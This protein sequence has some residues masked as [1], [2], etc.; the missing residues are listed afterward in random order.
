V[1]HSIRLG[2]IHG[3]AIKVHPSFA[4][5]LLWVCYQWGIAAHAGLAGIVFGTLVLVAV[6][7]CVLLHE[8]AHAIV[9]LRYGV[10]VQD[11]TLLPV[12]GVARVDQ[13]AL[14]PKAEAAI[15]LAG[16][17]LNL[18]IAAALTPFVILVAAMRHADHPL[19][20]LLYAGEL[21]VAGFVLYLWIANILLAVFN[22]LPAFPMDGGRVLRAVLSSFR[23][24]LSATR[25]AV[26]IGQV[27]ALVLAVGG[28][29][30][31]DY[32]TPLISAFILVSAWM[33][34]RHVEIEAS[35]RRLD[36]GQF[37]LWDAGGVRPDE[38]LAHAIKGG[39]RDLVVTQGT[40]VVGMLWRH[41][42][43]RHLN[44]AHHDLRV[45]DLMDR[46]FNAVE[47][48]DS[49]YDVHLWMRAANRTAVPV[50]I[51][52]KYRGIFTSERLAHVYTYLGQPRSG[53][54]LATMRSLLRR[55]RSRPATR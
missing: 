29:L 38:P 26:G 32:L 36:V 49:V 53:S 10:R 9:A 50:V 4:L 46:R 47:A 40:T 24:R 54:T 16:P 33:E 11:I 15:A 35:L 1:G 27:L 43:L 51:D 37:A 2:A 39:P 14:S 3:I 5:V 44:G 42:I 21:S 52:G 30:I 41:E 13:V 20:V 55:V 45:R 34:G 22:L 48:A 8:L 7:G 28:V 31:G 17:A 6:F 23:G 12:G 18:L 19:S 25:I